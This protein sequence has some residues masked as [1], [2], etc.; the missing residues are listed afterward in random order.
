MDVWNSHLDSRATRE[1]RWCAYELLYQY[2]PPMSIHEP[3]KRGT[4]LEIFVDET[5]S[6]RSPLIYSS[7][8]CL[9]LY[10]S[11]NTHQ[12]AQGSNVPLGVRRSA[13]SKKR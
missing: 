13:H 10:R 2:H 5:R 12:I 1:P 3:T 4:R 11:E 6:A 8:R 7:G 9:C